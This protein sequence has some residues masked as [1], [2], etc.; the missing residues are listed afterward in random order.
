[1]DLALD[2]PVDRPLDGIRLFADLLLDDVAHI[3]DRPRLHDRLADGPHARDKL[4]IVDG[5]LDVLEDCLTLEL[6]LDVPATILGHGANS[7]RCTT[8][9][10]RSR[11]RVRGRAQPYS[12]G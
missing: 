1:M 4:S 3:G 11:R 6:I 8:R 7:T 9:V 5:L 12:Q 10:A 2:R